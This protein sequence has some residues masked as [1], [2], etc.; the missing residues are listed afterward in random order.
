[1][2]RLLVATTNRG[3]LAELMPML[4][5]LGLTV[6][7]L[8]DVPAVPVAPEEQDTC[9]GNARDKALYYA[10]LTGLDVL[11]DDSG[12][13]VAALDGAPGVHSA[14]YAGPEADDADNRA[15]L[16]AELRDVQDRRARFV[17][18]LCLV[19]DGVPTVEVLGECTGVIAAAERGTL[20]FGYDSL[21][22]PDAA[23]A[24]GRTFAALE[25]EAKAAI[26]HRGRAL[27]TLLESL[28]ARAKGGAR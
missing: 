28:A 14:R 13:E 3:K 4:A 10:R 26:S 6:V 24:G 11:A 19:E 15:R 17:C 1:M 16:L 7:G 20:G 18:A 27:T 25:R 22:L 12:L 21:F 8:A 23:E 9:A 5:P 2:T